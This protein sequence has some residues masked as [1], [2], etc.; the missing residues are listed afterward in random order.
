MSHRHNGSEVQ[1]VAPSRKGRSVQSQSRSRYCG[2][3]VAW[4]RDMRTAI[5]S[6]V[7]AQTKRK[8]VAPQRAHTARKAALRTAAHGRTPSA[9]CPQSSLG[10]TG[11][12]HTP[13]G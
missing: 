6:T 3:P 8:E 4:A 5:R 1:A 13:R 11:P 10:G 2:A 7:S 9:R 12:E